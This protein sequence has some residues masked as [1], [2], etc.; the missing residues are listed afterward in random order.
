MIEDTW[1]FPNILLEQNTTKKGKMD[2]KVMELEFQAGKSKKYKMEEIQNSNVYANKAK[3][4]LPGPY[5][6]IAFKRY[7]EEENTWEPSFASQ[8]LKKPIN[9]YY[10]KYPEK[11]AGIFSPM[12]SNPPMARP[13]IK[14]I[15]L[16]T[17]RKRGQLA[18]ATIKQARNWILDARNI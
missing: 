3:G 2:K 4:Y 8:Y 18:N 6:L 15:R 7:S 1:C 14:P 16:I 17:R 13:T 12:N 10:K 11:S 5:Y 9:S